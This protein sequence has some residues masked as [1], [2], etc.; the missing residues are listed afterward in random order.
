MTQASSVLV[1]SGRRLLVLA[2]LGAWPAAPASAQDG[3]SEDTAPVD[4]R[5]RVVR[6]VRA[7]GP[8]EID[9]RLD[10]AAWARA[11][12]ARGFTQEEPDEGE[13]AMEET[14]VRV[15]YDDDNL[16][17]GA[18]LYDSEPS[19]IARQ[20]T[21]RDETG[22]AA[23]YIEFS[24][25]PNGDETTGYQFRVTAAGVQRDR[26]LFGDT[27]SDDAWDAVW[28]SAAAEN[29]E[30]WV[31]EARLPLSQ[32]RYEGSSGTQEWGVNFARRRIA[33]NERSEWA[34][35]PS[36]VHGN[37]SRFGQLRG[38]ELPDRDRHVELQPYLASSVRDAP[39]RPGNP[40]FDG[41]AQDMR[42]GADLRYLLGSTFVVDVALNPDFGQVEVD[43]QV[44]NLGAFETFFPERR[45]FFTRDDRIFNFNLSGFQNTLF[46]SRRI[47]RRPQGSAPDGAEFVSMPDETTIRG[48]AKITGRTN[49]GLNVGV[50]AAQ[51]DAEHGSAALEGGNEIVGFEAEPGTHY[52]IARLEQDLRDGQSRIGGIVTLVDRDLPANGSLDFLAQQAVT[53]GID[54]EHSWSDREW[55]FGGYWVDSEVEGS[56]QAITRI[57]RS[58]NH[59]FQ[60][61]DQD[62]MT[63]DP[64]ATSLSG[65]EWRLELERRSSRDWSGAAW[66]GRRTPGFEINDLGF[67][68]QTE[69]IQAGARADYREPTPASDRLQS[70]SFGFR[71]GH[72][73][74]NSVSE[75][76]SSRAAWREAHSGGRL[77]ADA[78]FTFHNWWQLRIDV[79]Y[80][81][82]V[83]SHGLT[84]GGPLM[85]NPGSGEI[86]VNFNTDRRDTLTWNA[87]ID[88]ED[89][90]R[91]GRELSAD[92]GVDARPRNG[93]N[94]SAELSYDRNRNVHQYV[95]QRDDA[96]FEATYGGRYYFADLDREE[97]A[98][99]LR[100]DFIFSPTLTLELFLQPFIS[101]GDFRSYKQLARASSFEF[102]RFADG[103]AVT[104]GGGVRCVD[105]ALCRH[106]GT[107]HIDHTGDGAPDIS[108][109]D[110]NFNLRSLRGNAVLRWEYR[111]G[112]RLYVV[113][114][115]SREARALRGDLDVSRD[116][117]ALLDSE[118]EHTFMIKV[119]RWF[120]F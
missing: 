89:G 10:E 84:R 107:I 86:G 31:A 119:D 64:D 23:G 42:A 120:D 118:G 47:G 39:A 83:L 115:H 93:L 18:R 78:N 112:S 96:S 62:Y 106:D 98:L 55:V 49:G 17:I 35:T 48:A 24:L 60:R 40:F 56:E 30:G 117:Q 113:W 80:R 100:A 95:A 116:A 15:L 59:R 33:D 34:F 72:S 82:E 5:D 69:R 46:H 9:G 13:P 99:N 75:D 92:V 29:D 104:E 110:R 66:V 4:S 27:R 52:S 45:P 79:G 3:S 57:Q 7:D 51:T 74:R 32:L 94:L 73:W 111:P 70:Y 25:D 91:G 90:M 105:G 87:S 88:Y 26:Y 102:M 50:L 76:Y 114:Q 11:E 2:L 19:R 81:P 22:R 67:S 109:R 103:E 58:P 97:L 36:G 14:E 43:P 44:V 53:R 8:I 37:V 54:F 63:L 77:N 65:S 68:T 101:A 108:F 6:A 38:L 21:R 41:T 71:T 20:L 85:T 16:Y 61:P 28:E 12:P 1:R